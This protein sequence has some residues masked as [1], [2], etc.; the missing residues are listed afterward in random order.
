MRNILDKKDKY[1]YDMY[2]D[3][4]SDVEF[5]HHMNF[6]EFLKDEDIY[7]QI[8]L[9]FYNITNLENW[10]HNK[11]KKEVRSKKINRII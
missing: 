4:Y 7:K 11:Y 6:E 3:F 2:K 10:Y 9:L 8:T 5:H 1:L